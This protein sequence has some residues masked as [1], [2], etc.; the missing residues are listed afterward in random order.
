M[1]ARTQITSADTT[2]TIAL[3]VTG[4]PGRIQPE[5]SSQPVLDRSDIVSLLVTGRT[6]AQGGLAT[7]VVGEQ[8]LGYLSGDLLNFA[9]RAFGLDS[10]RID[11]GLALDDLRFDPTAIAGEKDPGSRLTIT[12][13]FTRRVEVVL[14]QDLSGSGK[15]SW[16][17]TW[18]PRR[19]IAFRV[20][21][22]DNRDATFE[23][24]QELSFGGT[25]A[26]RQVRQRRL[27]EE[28]VGVSFSG[29]GAETEAPALRAVLKLKPGKRF[30]FYQW[31]DDRDRLVRYFHDRQ[32]YEARV[33]AKR[34]DVKDKEG[35]GSVELQYKSGPAL[36]V[37]W[38]SR[39]RCCPRTPWFRCARSGRERCS[40]A[41][42]SRT[43]RSWLVP[44][45][46]GR[47]TCGRRSRRPSTR[48]ARRATTSRP[49]TSRLFR[50][51]TPRSAPS[52]GRGT[53]A[54][55]A[56]GSTRP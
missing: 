40:T 2:Y 17:A 23:F 43:C 22:L 42:W 37:G 4:A 36:V 30:D 20:V 45:W 27:R 35:N 47:A 24:S 44:R 38:T 8:V 18:R 49:R 52:P 48:P 3:Q 41:S 21:S 56:G 53:R 54:S 16:V 26:S 12:K 5:L 51:P 13:N 55:T 15:L 19:A 34:R 14:S 1:L 11:R 28:V 6:T 32:F 33:S 29:A 9:G 25:A 7:H 50:V 10:V 39:V 46:P 31:Q